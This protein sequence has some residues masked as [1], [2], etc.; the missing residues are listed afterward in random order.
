MQFTQI[1]AGGLENKA[2]LKWSLQV[3]QPSLLTNYRYNMITF[4]MHRSWIHTIQSCISLYHDWL[5]LV[6]WLTKPNL[7]WSQ[8]GL[9]SR[10]ISCKHDCLLFSCGDQH[11]SYQSLLSLTTTG[12]Q[13]CR[14][15]MVNTLTTTTTTSTTITTLNVYLP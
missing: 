2:A 4:V 14:F 9:V 10:L 3:S 1:I 11:S 13:R 12:Q 15:K 8:N 7:F 5:V 6:L